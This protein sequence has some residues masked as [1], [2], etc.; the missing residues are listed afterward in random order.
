[1]HRTK[2]LN[3]QV[4]RLRYNTSEANGSIKSKETEWVCNGYGQ[5]VCKQQAENMNGVL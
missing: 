4:V 2:S 1:M 5:W 3:K